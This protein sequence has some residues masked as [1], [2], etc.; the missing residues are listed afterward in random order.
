[1]SWPKVLLLCWTIVATGLFVSAIIAFSAPDNK[2]VGG[3]LDI[4]PHPFRPPRPP[5]PGPEPAPAPLDD[6]DSKLFAR[7]RGHVERVS[8]DRATRRL[9]AFSAELADR[10]DTMREDGTLVVGDD[11]TPVQFIGT[12]FLAGAIFAVVKKVVIWIV[13]AI[14]VA[15]II[16]LFWSYWPVIVSV[17]VGAVTLVAAPA[18]WAAGK[19]TAK[20]E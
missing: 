3:P 11:Q 19:L 4:L 1:M 6:N 15:A 12:S 13:K 20:K 10:L 7:L 14:L 9:E 5:K 18:G 2:V 8:D 16:G 17:F